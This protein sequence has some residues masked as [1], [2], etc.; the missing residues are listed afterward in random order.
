MGFL[1]KT[2]DAIMQFLVDRGFDVHAYSNSLH[3][4]GSFM[5]IIVLA[6][7]GV[8]VWLSAGIVLILGI[9]KEL[10][11]WLVRG[12]VFSWKDIL[13]DIIGIGI[14]VVFCGGIRLVK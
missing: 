10:F 12:K 14:G 2:Y 9:L 6:V 13:F 7:S 4:F 3:L 1:V 11:D 5:L 8:G